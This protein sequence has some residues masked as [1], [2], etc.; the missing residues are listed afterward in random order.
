[1]PSEVLTTAL[2]K[3][4][5]LLEQLVISCGRCDMASLVALVDRCPRLQLLDVSG[6]Y[7]ACGFSCETLEAK[8]K[9][10]IK[11][12]RLP[13]CFFHSVSVR[14]IPPGDLF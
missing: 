2:A 12:L 9:S 5:P 14:Y 13:G 7:H 10:K 3:K 11:D 8:L 1:M 4:L 6:C